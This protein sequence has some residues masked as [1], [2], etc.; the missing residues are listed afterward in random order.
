MSV[1]S[2]LS[3]P[4]NFRCLSFSSSHTYMNSPTNKVTLVSPDDADVDVLDLSFPESA[5][6]SGNYY[7]RVMKFRV[8][9]DKVTVYWNGEDSRRYDLVVKV[10][11]CAV[12]YLVRNDEGIFEP[13]SHPEHP[14]LEQRLIAKA[15]L[16]DAT[17][18]DTG[19]FVLG[20][21]TTPSNLNRLLGEMTSKGSKIVAVGSGGLEDVEALTAVTS[22]G[23][24]PRR[25]YDYWRQIDRSR[26]VREQTASISYVGMLPGDVLEFDVTRREPALPPVAAATTTTASS[27]SAV[28]PLSPKSGTLALV[29]AGIEAHLRL[30]AEKS[31]VEFAPAALQKRAM[32]LARR[33]TTPEQYEGLR[34]SVLFGRLSLTAGESEE[35]VEDVGDVSTPVGGLPPVAAGAALEAVTP[36]EGKR[37]AR[38][39][40]YVTVPASSPSR[41]VSPSASLFSPSSEKKKH[42]VEIKVSTVA[43]PPVA[44]PTDN[45][46]EAPKTSCLRVPSPPD[47]FDRRVREVEE[48]ME[49]APSADSSSSPSDTGAS[50]VSFKNVAQTCYEIRRYGGSRIKSKRLICQL[51]NLADEKDTRGNV[52]RWREALLE[53]H[54]IDPPLT[55]AEKQGLKEDAIFFRYQRLMRLGWGNRDNEHYVQDDD[56]FVAQLQL[57]GLS[58]RAKYAMGV[59]GNDGSGATYWHLD[60]MVEEEQERKQE[61][62]EMENIIA[63]LLP[64]I[65]PTDQQSYDTEADYDEDEDEEYYEDDEQVPVSAADENVAPDSNIIATS[66]EEEET[67]VVEQEMTES[68]TVKPTPRV[69]FPPAVPDLPF[70]QMF[71]EKK[72]QSGTSIASTGAEQTKSPPVQI[73][74]KKEKSVPVT[75]TKAPTASTSMEQAAPITPPP[76]LTYAQVA[77]RPFTPS[78]VKS[79]ASSAKPVATP[80]SAKSPVP[81]PSPQSSPGS[82][83]MSWA[84]IVAKPAPPVTAESSKNVPSATSGSSKAPSPQSSSSSRRS[85]QPST[86]GGKQQ[87]GKGSNRKSS[88]KK[89]NRGQGGK[90]SPTPQS[91]TTGKVEETNVTQTGKTCAPQSSQTA[92]VVRKDKQNASIKKSSPPPLSEAGSAMSNGS[93]KENTTSKKNGSKTK[94]PPKSGET[95][96]VSSGSSP[97]SRST[98]GSSDFEIIYPTDNDGPE[99]LTT[100]AGRAGY[101]IRKI[102]QVIAE[103]QP[104]I[105]HEQSEG[106]NEGGSPN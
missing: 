35:E 21:S 39:I 26:V 8:A 51:I 36:A 60:E 42:Y 23:L 73:E 86:K 6:K 17:F 89:N 75:P 68:V 93:D 49:L 10:D 101:L 12:E 2:I 99:D 24:D 81:S 84:Q 18:V 90:K 13:V 92:A 27:S 61:V 22:I 82:S 76:R 45:E 102:R 48:G 91:K 53:D 106:S 1:Q 3:Q 64:T 104:P 38:E 97:S 96:N 59:Y 58:E 70:A 103:M 31:A 87:K 19:V 9:V 94:N 37:F 52:R 14:S 4:Q 54:N 44:P 50:K 33:G 20:E 32:S 30:H 43:G 56:D 71:H 88:P 15:Y 29:P 28:A 77:T 95:P 34:A 74:Q 62:E 105:T 5:G 41:P 7:R 25:L 98:P 78:P 83:G 16:K 85:G 80:P 100:C 66:V 46:G 79:V 47:A 69:K 67:R 72:S 11:P 40:V 55:K 63:E 65:V 57:L